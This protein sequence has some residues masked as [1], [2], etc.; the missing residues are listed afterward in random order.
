M[1]S[2][3]LLTKVASLIALTDDDRHALEALPVVETTTPRRRAIMAQGTMPDFVY[4]IQSGWAA[5]YEVRAD[6]SRRITGFLLPGDFCGIHAICHAAMDHA[7][8]ALTECTLARIDGAAFAEV[9][10][11][12]SAIN[13]AI[14][15]AKLIEEAVLRKWLLF[16]NDS[17]QSVA[18]L[19]CE[20]YVR[21]A[22]I[23][24]AANGQCRLPLTQEEIGNALGITSVHTN[25]VIQR[26]RSEGMIDL[27]QHD[28]TIKDPAALTRAAAFDR[29]YLEPWSSE[30]ALSLLD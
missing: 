23:G 9:A 2:G 22:I 3:A 29:S 1:K 19:L 16:S 5:R 25:R 13:Q 12:S 24:L 15:R 28:L 7:I 14:W 4:V 18:H 26:L 11:R 30:N 21:A 27:V 20:M 17:Y 6:G 8:I 10:H